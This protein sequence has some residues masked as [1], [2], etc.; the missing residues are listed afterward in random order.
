MEL[1]NKYKEIY[2]LLGKAVADFEL[3]MRADLKKYDEQE[4][5]W[6]K[7]VRI[8]KFEFCVELLWK[9]AKIHIE[10]IEEKFLTPKLL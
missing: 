6:I 5:D 4:I 9:T 1:I 2:I 3:S 10:S 7:N 8:Q